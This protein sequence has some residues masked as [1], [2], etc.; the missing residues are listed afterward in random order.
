MNRGE[1]ETFRELGKWTSPLYNPHFDPK[2]WSIVLYYDPLDGG[3]ASQSERLRPQ[4]PSTDPIPI[5]IDD[6]D[7]PPS[8]TIGEG[9]GRPF[10][11][12]GKQRENHAHSFQVDDVV[13]DLLMFNT[14]T[15]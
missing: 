4:L 11:N 3:G 7:M 2:P 10:G 13:V 12:R 8:P 5:Q 15:R 6:E 9:Q 14:T 1:R